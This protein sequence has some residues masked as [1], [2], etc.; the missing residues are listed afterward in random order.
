VV[1]HCF[2]TEENVDYFGHKPDVSYYGVNEMSES[3]TTDFLSW[4]ECKKSKVS[5]NRRVLETYSEDDV[6][7]LRQACR[8]FRREF[9]QIGNIELFLEAITIASAC[10]KLSRK[11]F[12][13]PDT[14]GLIPT[15]GYSGNSKYSKKAVMWLL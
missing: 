7:V 4:Y 12:L 5:D 3:Q 9:I 15:D 10:N 14:I 8:V 13:K 2:N 6:T 1:P 11:G